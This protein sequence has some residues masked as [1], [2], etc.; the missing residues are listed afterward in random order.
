MAHKI[1][2]TGAAGFIGGSILADFL[3]SSNPLLK[4][5]NISAAVRSQEQADALSKLGINVIRLDLG[6][7]EAVVA[8]ILG[9]DISV[10]I[11][12]AS[13]IDARLVLPLITGLG[14]QR[15]LNGKKT[16]F[17]H[18]A[19]TS[20]F[21]KSTGWPHE[22]FNDTDPIFETEKQIEVHF[23]VRVVNIAVTEHAM[24]QGVPSFVVVPPLRTPAV[25]ISDLM[26]F[27]ECLVSKILSGESPPSG[28]KGYYLPMSHYFNWWGVLGNLATKLHDRGLT[29]DSETNVWPSDEVAASAL[30]IPLPYVRVLWDSG[31]NVSTEKNVKLGW[32]PEWNENRMLLSLDDEIQS[33]IDSEGPKSSSLDAMKKAAEQGSLY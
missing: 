23:P 17:I 25:Q 26:A 22:E 1:L 10:V 4:K 5:D 30:S 31:L 20:S 6:D 7:E 2:I 15:E 11:H 19:G 33:V 32:K 27:Y 13:C 14:Q 21:Y 12:T 16:A 3:A 18:I 8:A 24:A 9:N 29:K 28:D